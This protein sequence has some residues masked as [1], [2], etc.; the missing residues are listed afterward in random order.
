MEQK[1]V[2][3]LRESLKKKSAGFLVAA[4]NVA[5]LWLLLLLLLFLLLLLL[6]LQREIQSILITNRRF[7]QRLITAAV[8][9]PK[10]FLDAPSHLYK[11]V[12][13]SVCPYVRVSVC[14]LAF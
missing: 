6:G 8:S 3:Q 9:V 14:P 11:G 4:A 5:L 13:L 2:E 1:S 7:L 10:V 12:R